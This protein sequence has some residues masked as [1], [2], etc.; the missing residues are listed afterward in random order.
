MK[1]QLLHPSGKG[2][3]ARFGHSACNFMNKYMCV[4]GGRND[5]LY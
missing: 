2:P 5:L 3:V 4:Y 1:A